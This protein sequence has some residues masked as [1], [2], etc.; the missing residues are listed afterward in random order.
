MRNKQ[1][2]FN[3]SLPTDLILYANNLVKRSIYIDV[4]DYIRGLMRKDRDLH[5]S[6]MRNKID[7]GWDS[8]K[9]GNLLN[10]NEVFAKLTEYSQLQ[11]N[12]IQ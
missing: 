3:L 7:Q 10:G 4:A 9:A 12:K 1:T 5:I 11:R 8:A 6:D 2:E